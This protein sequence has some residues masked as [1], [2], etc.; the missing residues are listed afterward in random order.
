MGLPYDRAYLE[1]REAVRL[2][3]RAQEATRQAEALIPHD[4]D[5]IL[6]DQVRK[7]DTKLTSALSR[8]GEWLERAGQE[9]G[10]EPT[11]FSEGGN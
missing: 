3:S 7:A 4:R 2:L 10:V 5:M 6:A 11:L 8:A 1:A 9:A